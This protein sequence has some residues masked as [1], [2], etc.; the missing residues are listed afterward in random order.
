MAICSIL[1]IIYTILLY[2]VATKTRLYKLMLIIFLMLGAQITYGLGQL[3]AYKISLVVINQDSDRHSLADLLKLYLWMICGLC[4]TYVLGNWLFV[5]SYLQLAYRL[6]LVI[7][8]KNPMFYERRITVLTLFVS[9][10]IVMA[11]LFCTWTDLNYYFHG[12]KKYAT[13]IGAIVVNLFEIL[14]CILF[15][16]AL[17]KIYYSVEKSKYRQ[18]CQINVKVIAWHAS[19]YI[20]QILAS[21][22]TDASFFMSV[23]SFIKMSIFLVVM[24]GISELILVSIIYQMYCEYIK[25]EAII[26]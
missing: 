7:A 1:G 13:A 3:Y 17:R 2:K 24:T 25:H 11:A 8:Y 16:I 15:G 20:L 22:M 18:V 21:I 6:E 10:L 26:Q 5:S 9:V 4:V 19:G 23:E 14:Y 12:G